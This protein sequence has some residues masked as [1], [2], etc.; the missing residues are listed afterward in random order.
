MDDRGEK[1]IRK[2]TADRPGRIDVVVSEAFADLSRGRVQRMLAEGAITVRGEAARK[3]QHVSPGDVIE[4]RVETFVKAAPASAPELAV[5]YEDEWLVVID[6]PQGIVVHGGPGDAGAS[7]VA[8]FTGRYGE[9]AAQFDVERPGVV[10]RLDKDTTGIVLLG[11]TPAAQAALSKAFEER[12]VVKRYLAVVAGVPAKARA[13][14]DA[15]IGRHSGDRTKMAIVRKGRPAQ[16][17]YELLGGDGT[18]SLLAVRLHTGRTHQIRVHLAAIRVPVWD[19]ATYGA[20]GEGRQLLHAWRLSVPHPDGGRLT[21]TSPMP[22][23][24][25]AEVRQMGL[26]DVASRYEAPT[27]PERTVTGEGA[28]EGHEEA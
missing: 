8:W 10:H 19:D 9:L 3:S 5:L 18:R 25:A 7:V 24:M 28:D 4:I 14:I 26:E 15:P 13:T 22:A 12:T 1:D 6:K 20:A 27:P 17:D 21:V 2:L 23:D 11:K 16:T